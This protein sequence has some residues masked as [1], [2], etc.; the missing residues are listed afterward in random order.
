MMD[1][2]VVVPDLTLGAK[3]LLIKKIRKDRRLELKNP[4]IKSEIPFFNEEMLL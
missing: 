2:R 4:K 3:N 1:K